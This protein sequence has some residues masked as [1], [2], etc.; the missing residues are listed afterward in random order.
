MARDEKR[1]QF[2]LETNRVGGASGS[3]SQWVVDNF[4]SADGNPADPSAN[5]YGFN[6]DIN[7]DVAPTRVRVRTGANAGSVVTPDPLGFAVNGRIHFKELNVDRVQHV[8]PSGGAATALYGIKL[9]NADIR[10]NFTATPIN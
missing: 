7:L 4:H 1:N 8:H 5:T 10:A 2:I 3:G 6:A 9:Q